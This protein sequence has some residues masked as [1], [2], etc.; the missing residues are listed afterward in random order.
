MADVESP[1]VAVKDGRRYEPLCDD[2]NWGEGDEE[3]ASGKPVDAMQ[4]DGQA[5]PSSTQKSASP[6][7]I[8]DPNADKDDEPLTNLDD[9]N[10]APAA[11][12]QAVTTTNAPGPS[13]ELME[14]AIDA[15]KATQPPSTQPQDKKQAKQGSRGRQPKDAMAVSTIKGKRK[16]A[17]KNAGEDL[18][19]STVKS[20]SKMATRAAAKLSKAARD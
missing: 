10:S 20:A 17:A 6:S 3:M 5:L 14:K 18:D 8:P 4:G 1:I 12:Q 11:H 13:A 19:S 16:G 2:V 7:Q 15:L 9:P